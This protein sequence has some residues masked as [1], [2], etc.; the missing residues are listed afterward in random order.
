MRRLMPMQLQ[1]R[2]EVANHIDARAFVSL[3]SD[4]VGR[5]VEMGEALEIFMVYVSSDEI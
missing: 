4:L 3:L 1:W 5:K 2:R